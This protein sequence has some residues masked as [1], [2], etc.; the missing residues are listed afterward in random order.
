MKIACGQFAPEYRNTEANL[1]TI[2]RLAKKA[3]ADIL[4]LPELALTGYFFKERAE[5]DALGE[6]ITGPL[7][8]RLSDI[9]RD[10]ELAIITGFLERDGDEFYNSALAFDHTGAL[11]GHYRKVHLFYFEKEVF[12]KGDLGFPVFDLATRSGIARTGMLVCYDWRFPEAARSLA[13]KGAE[14]IA[15]PS[16]IVTTTGRL[17]TT[18]ETRAFENKVALAFADRTGTETNGD[19]TLTFRGESAIYNFNGDGLALASPSGDEI[20]R[21]EVDLA[22]TRNKEINRF[23]EIFSDR[24]ENYGL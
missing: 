4:V 16:N 19:E 12:S 8:T 20:I 22:K 1:H 9:A 24:L 6:A 3:S 15:M 14:L 21:A 10:N 13:I 11:A 17:H 23:N 5:V 2:E 7:A 18:L